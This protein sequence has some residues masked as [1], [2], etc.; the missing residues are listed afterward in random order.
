MSS[1][2]R[3]KTT[4]QEMRRSNQIY[5]ES[6]I[7]YICTRSELKSLMLNRPDSTQKL[8]TIYSMPKQN[9]GNLR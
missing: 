1:V 2:N 7:S 6:F 4:S 3:I 8:N 9:Y 5:I